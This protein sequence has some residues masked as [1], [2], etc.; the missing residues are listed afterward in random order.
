MNI[1]SLIRAD[2]R[3]FKPYQSAR[4]LYPKGMFFDANENGF[5]STVDLP[6]DKELNRYPDPYSTELRGALAKFLDVRVENIF[7]GNGAD[8]AID[9]LIRLF[10][11]RNEEILLM[12]PTYGMYRV[13]ASVA[14]VKIGTFSLS[15]DFTLNVDAFLARIAPETKMVFCCSPNNP[16]GTLLKLEDIEKICK[17]F[18]GIVVLD[19]AYI[20]F[21]SQ[22]SFVA[23]IKDFE[24]II[25]LRTFSKAW[26]LACIRVGYAVGNT[27]IIEYLN[28]IKPPYNLNRV[29]AKIALEALGRSSKMF[30]FRD[31]ILKER[32]RLAD[33]LGILG[34]EVYP[35]E[36]NFLLVRYPSLSAI[37]KRL[38]DEF[39][40]IIRDFGSQPLLKDCARIS[41]GAPNENG[42]LL[43]TLK[44]IL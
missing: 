2:L 8:E 15:A 5:G 9:L 22:A 10:V 26:G 25:V 37:A 40:I 29:S 35:S 13:A 21:A 27:D 33:G 24:N 6:L 4:S 14:G 3:N 34:F 39:G 20:E 23:R 42:A 43:T 28:K 17:N 38:A 41:V 7:V 44:K 31:K 30:E 16:T 19:E 18:R 11:E 12:E 36:A 1:L 32:A